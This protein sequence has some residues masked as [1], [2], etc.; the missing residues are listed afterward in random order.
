MKHS[1]DFYGL[2][3][4]VH[5]T[6]EELIEEVRRDFAYFFIPPKKCRVRVDLHLKTPPYDDLP[7]LP[8][9][10]LPLA[11]FVSKS[12]IPLISTILEKVSPYLIARDNIA[13]SMVRTSIWSTKF[14]IY[15]FCLPADSISTKKE[16][17][18]F[19]PLL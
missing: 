1:Y 5:S 17:T 7:S 14:V 2:T 12:G 18:G 6:E 19:M 16:S 8:A 13:P 4:E 11:M 3:V 15:S 9:S 10:F